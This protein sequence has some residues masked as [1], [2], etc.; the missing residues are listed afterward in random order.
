M[1]FGMIF[2]SLVSFLVSASALAA[3]IAVFRKRKKADKFFVPY[4]G[5]LFCTGCL[6]FFV[7][8]RLILAWFGFFVL[9]RFFFYVV[10]VFVFLSGPFLAY[11]L[12]LKISRSEKL[13]K[14]ITA[15]FGLC[16]VASLFLLFKGGITESG[17]TYFATKFVINRQAFVFF[18]A[19]LIPLFLA[20]FFDVVSGIIARRPF[21]YSLVIVIYLALGVFDEQGIIAGW[22]LVIFRLLFAGLIKPY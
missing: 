9:D 12:A 7:S 13:A 18:I 21:V 14:I 3:G 1:S 10:Q 19:M 15:V 8:L 17:A 4:S 22:G 11:F 6:W 5:F 20:A 16:F 2:T